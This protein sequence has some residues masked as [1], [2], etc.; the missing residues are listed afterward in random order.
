[1]RLEVGGGG[2]CKLLGKELRNVRFLFVG[3]DGIFD[4]VGILGKKIVMERNIF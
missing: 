4:R 1:M 2:V 3:F